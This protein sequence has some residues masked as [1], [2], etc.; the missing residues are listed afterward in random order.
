M[1][2]SNTNFLLLSSA[3]MNSQGHI[4]AYNFLWYSLFLK[5]DVL[6]TFQT[7][8]HHPAENA[9]N[10]SVGKNVYDKDEAME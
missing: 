5:K 4:F 2:F 10:S 6:R 3:L 1:K 8:I 7:L 9:E